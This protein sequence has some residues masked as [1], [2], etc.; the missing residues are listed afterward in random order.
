MPPKQQFTPREQQQVNA[1]LEDIMP[2]D[3]EPLDDP[4][5]QLAGE[6]A[7][8]Y[9]LDEGPIAKAA[10][11]DYKDK[12]VPQAHWSFRALAVL[13]S[14]F[15]TRLILEDIRAFDGSYD[16][17]A[18]VDD[19]YSKIVFLVLSVCLE[20]SPEVAR[21]F[22][23]GIKALSPRLYAEILRNT[24]DKDDPTENVIAAQGR[25][26]EAAILAE[27]DGDGDEELEDEELE[28]DAAPR[29]QVQS[30]VT[31][32]TDIDEA[33]VSILKPK[34]PLP[35]GQFL[36]L[37]LRLL[38]PVFA[39]EA[40]RYFNNY[41]AVVDAI[42]EAVQRIQ[43]RNAHLD[44]PT[45]LALQQRARGEFMEIAAPDAH[46]ALYNE[47][48]DIALKK[49]EKE[50]EEAA[51]ARQIAL[52]AESAR[53]LEDVKSPELV[54]A[55]KQVIRDAPSL[56]PYVNV[57]I[58]YA[59]EAEAFTHIASAE[60]SSVVYL[61]IVG[62]IKLHMVA[63]MKI[64]LRQFFGSYRDG[65]HF[66]PGSKTTAFLFACISKD[67]IATEGSQGERWRKISG[68]ISA[69]FPLWPGRV[70]DYF[71]KLANCCIV[72]FEAKYHKKG[73]SDAEIA[74]K[75]NNLFLA[76]KL[77]I[78][79][80]LHALL[81][82]P[83]AGELL[84]LALYAGADHKRY[85]S[86]P[87]SSAST[88]ADVSK[89]G[90]LMMSENMNQ[91]GVAFE[92]LLSGKIDHLY[93]NAFIN[94]LGQNI[95]DVSDSESGRVLAGLEKAV[96]DWFGGI[97]ELADCGLANAG[98]KEVARNE[99]I[100]LLITSLEAKKLEARVAALKAQVHSSSTN[101]LSFPSLESAL[102]FH[103]KEDAAV[104]VT[105][106]QPAAATRSTTT[107]HQ[108]AA[109]ARSTTASQQPAVANRSTTASTTAPSTRSGQQSTRR[110][111]SGGNSRGL[112]TATSLGR[113]TTSTSRGNGG[114]GGN[115]RNTGGRGSTGLGK[116]QRNPNHRE[117]C[118]HH[119][120]NGYARAV[121]II[122]HDTANCQLVTSESGLILQWNPEEDTFKVD[123]ESTNAFRATQF[124]FP[125]LD[126]KSL[127]RISQGFKGRR[128]R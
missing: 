118:T 30:V 45:M 10:Y 107:S 52:P 19:L 58:N 105:S 99:A 4:F 80:D 44:D 127:E 126:E 94:A 83:G 54:D 125:P 9:A 57:L 87:L 55:I 78:P 116:Y 60:N 41:N 90:L 42:I 67:T 124:N 93:K 108:P 59:R 56:L 98:F 40:D 111:N 24:I 28:D 122:N 62:K 117:R 84:K 103:V 115:G 123:V 100:S 18:H 76:N 22:F 66:P 39:A 96:I 2:D 128:V 86:R 79:H 88:T 11:L 68:A 12:F 109:A 114:N 8:G 74:V 37:E 102:S 31:T 101:G 91:L 15:L 5:A 38:G 26:R 121:N 47:A 35:D 110:S 49:K 63:S 43:H 14:A 112:S 71:A 6:Q 72:R 113:A 21:G 75:L 13:C 7:L 53:L 34:A 73:L 25:R 20:L 17:Y 51:L 29:I 85:E 61:N 92:V 48:R 81:E 77:C 82:E 46:R 120:T 50:Q 119:I 23:N 69:R 1:T 32:F 89:A 33:V 27:L 70:C 104:A 65:L 97:K 106:Q 95:P 3:E 36:K 64:W 16:Q